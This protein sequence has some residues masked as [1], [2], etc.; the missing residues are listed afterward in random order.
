MSWPLP[1]EFNEAVQT[2]TLA[3]ADPDLK[4]GQA[5]VGAS[6]LPLPRS[7]NFADVYQIRSAGRDWAV[8]C[9]TR[10]AVGMDERYRKI[11]AALAQLN[12]PFTIGFTFLTEGVRVGGRWLPAVKMEWVEGLLLNQFVRENAGKPAVLD[13]LGAMWS[14]LCKRL[15]EAGIAHADLQHGNV[16][17]V[18]GPKPGAF[19]LKLIDY[20]GM[21][22]PALANS[23]SGET[24]HPAFQHPARAATRAYSPDL[25]RFPHI[26]IATALKGLAVLGQSLWDRYDTGDN[27]LFVESDFQHPAAS[28]LMRQ[29]WASGHPAV[30]ALVGNLA[31]AC[32]KPIPQ[33]LWLDQIA[34]EGVPIPLPPYYAR[35]ATAALG[36]SQKFTTGATTGEGVFPPTRRSAATSPTREG[37]EEPNSP[38]S[39]LPPSGGGRPKAGWGGVPPDNSRPAR[40]FPVQP[41]VIAAAVFVACTAGAIVALNGKKQDAAAHATPPAD[42]PPAPKP[43]EPEPEPPDTIPPPHLPSARVEPVEP[44]NPGPVVIAVEQAPPPRA[45]EPDPPAREPVPDA[46]AI[47]RA[48]ATVRQ[49]LKEEYAKSKT[50]TEK[51]A[52]AQKLYDTAVRT[53]NDPAA[54]FV[55]LRDAR[56]FAVEGNDPAL[57]VKALAT[58]GQL[59]E[60]N[61]A[62]GQR[63][64]LEKILAGAGQGLSRAVFEAA[65]TCADAAHA[66]DEFAEA[67]TFTTL[68]TVAARKA[69]LGPTA[70]EDVDFRTA[71][72]K[73]ALATLKPALDVLKANPDDPKANAAAGR[74]RCFVQ[75][76]WPEGLKPL[77]KGDVPHLKA[78]AEAEL[79]TPRTGVPDLAAADAWWVASQAEGE[80]DARAAASRARH[81]YARAMPGLMGL[82][83]AKAEGR[84][85]FT[86]AGVEHRPGLLVKFTAVNKGPSFKVPPPRIDPLIDFAAG[87]FARFYDTDKGKTAP[88]PLEAEWSG[89]V[90][91]PRAGRYRLVAA[92]PNAQDT[93]KVRLDGK[94]VID[95]ATNKAG[96]KDAAVT[97]PDRPVP[98]VV[99]FVGINATGHTARLMWLPPGGAEEEPLPAEFLFHDRKKADAALK[100]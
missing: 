75:G 11:G 55:L 31:L 45:K 69:N 86:L 89:V 23:P 61:P 81:W 70:A 99:E 16:L 40:K 66:G 79:A 58:T 48:E 43:P 44:A 78:A 39:H 84:L 83:K 60:V 57:A 27:L 87:E 64:A 28:P 25:D 73:T 47:V 9:F 8:K 91:P 6:G 42:S 26:V 19:G 93:V 33:T 38:S 77:A 5:V 94:L 37:G 24:G 85:A 35:D 90:V 14:R 98:L 95:T 51:K 65:I 49:T 92:V 68:A 67:L 7:G 74:F 15:R 3:F 17:L 100:K 59:F 30:Q 50:A 22:V 96:R 46:G 63:A 1:H 36:L 4:A 76:R 2:P 97:L 41:V 20:D 10:P 62:P 12:Q 71:E 80:P 72:A 53:V 56:D 29:L 52:L 34:P 13:G 18:P 21:Y 32:T 54:R 88:I 82:D